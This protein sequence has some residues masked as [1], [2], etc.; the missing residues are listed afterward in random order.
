M[1]LGNLRLRSLEDVASN[2]LGSYSDKFN[3]LVVK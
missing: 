3:F 1:D 2:T